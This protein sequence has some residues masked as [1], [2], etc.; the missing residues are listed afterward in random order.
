MLFKL[1]V[2]FRM[3][4]QLYH[5]RQTALSIKNWSCCIALFNKNGRFTS[6]S[7]GVTGL[8]LLW[9]V[10][11]CCCVSLVFNIL[12][13]RNN[14]LT[15]KVF[16][17][18]VSHILC[19]GLKLLQRCFF[20]S[21]LQKV[22]HWSIFTHHYRCGQCEHHSWEAE[23]PLSVLDNSSQSGE[24][25]LKGL[26]SSSSVAGD[27]EADGR[28]L[29]PR[30]QQHAG[31]QTHL[32]PGETSLHHWQRHLTARPQVSDWSLSTWSFF[33]VIQKMQTSSSDHGAF[34]VTAVSKKGL[35][36]FLL[37]HVVILSNNI[38]KVQC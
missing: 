1:W 3:F 10:C 4:S 22:G 30:G 24:V 15:P 36:V 6:Q 29:W 33:H 5:R 26:F 25:Q 12:V 7:T 8:T 9:S 27:P 17:S 35:R 2:V 16:S 14:P 21:S 38:M 31:G 20:P 37:N 32:Q 23:E 28:R 13:A 18:F 19:K 11:V 34:S